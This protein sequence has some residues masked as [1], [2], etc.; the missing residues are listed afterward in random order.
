MK[1][2]NDY[3]ELLD[4]KIFSSS[5]DKAIDEIMSRKKV[6]VVS[7]NPEVLYTALSDKELFDNFTGNEGFIIPDGVGVQVSAKL[8]RK[9]VKEKI[10]GIEV[11]K[12]LLSRLEQQGKSV[13]FLGS[14]DDTINA[15]AEKVKVHYPKLDIVGYRNGYFDM[16]NC[17]DVVEEIHNKKPY[18]LFVAMGCPRQER[19]ILKVMKES[20]I[21]I[22]M[23]VGG[24][25]DVIAEKLKRAPEWMINLS[26]EWLYRVSK[27][28]WRIKRLGSI[29]KFILKAGL[30]RTEK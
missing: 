29:P 12:A 8:Q 23:G 26:L 17:E 30:G 9:P 15:F 3:I 5:F 11:L 16:N 6:H 20:D 18:A 28:P 22:Y 24:S 10:A 25:F 27:E 1:I 4:Y 19:F 2:N 14:T 13:Y 21:S 7:G